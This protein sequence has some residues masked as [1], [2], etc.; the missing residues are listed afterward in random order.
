MEYSV[1]F[2]GFGGQGALFAG[3]MLAYAAM[4][5]GLEVTWYP[6]YGPEMRGGTAHCTVIVADE[7]VGSPVVRYPDAVVAMNLP[8][9]NKYEGLV[10]AGGVLLWDSTLVN[11]AL[12]REDV[13]L[14]AIPANEM[15]ARHGDV[16]LVNVAMLGALCAAMPEAM[17]AALKTKLGRAGV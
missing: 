7:T 5:A 13:Q 11:R 2:S 10:K 14:I 16:R 15:A 12:Q 8:S 6:S 4:E 9:A 1:I 17:E 3:Q